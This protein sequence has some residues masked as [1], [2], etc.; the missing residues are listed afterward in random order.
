MSIL[1]A[2]NDGLAENNWDEADVCFLIGAILAAIA[3]IAYGAGVGTVTRPEEGPDHPTDA[4]TTKP[5]GG[6]TAVRSPRPNTTTVSSQWWGTLHYRAHEI[7]AAMMS[8]AVA[9]IAFGLFLQ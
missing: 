1:M 2:V 7:A 5:T 6:T 4:T 3:A 9:A 8:L